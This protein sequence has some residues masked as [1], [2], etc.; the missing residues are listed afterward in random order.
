MQ[1]LHC[2]GETGRREMRV[3][4]LRQGFSSSARLAAVSEFGNRPFT[5]LFDD[6]SDFLCVCLVQV[7]R[8]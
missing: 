3:V 2:R 4:L 1:T 8:D 6:R 7:Y 5:P